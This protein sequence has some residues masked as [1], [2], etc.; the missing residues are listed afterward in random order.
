MKLYHG[1]TIAV[2]IPKILENQRLL[3]FGKGFYTTSSIE[4]AERWAIIKMK[5][6][7]NPVA[8]VSEY[9]INDDIFK[10]NDKILVFEDA[11]IQWLDFVLK[12]RR[13][14]FQHGFDIV[15]GA[16][17]NDKLF[18]AIK[19]FESG[20]LSKS[21]TIE[22]LKTHLLFDQISFHNKKILKELKFIKSYQI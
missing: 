2:T 5:R 3:D 16:V 4:Q 15:K 1:S 21:E 17:A 10:L 7:P 9:E 12:N 11:D 13:E 14:D 6:T 22:R 18:A 20:F 8:I 19:L